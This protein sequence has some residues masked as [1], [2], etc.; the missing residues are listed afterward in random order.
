MCLG[1]SILHSNSSKF[2]NDNSIR[3]R[4][5][6]LLLAFKKKK[7]RNGDWE[8]LSYFP[9]DI[10]L[11]T[12]ELCIEILSL[13]H[14]FFFSHFVLLPPSYSVHTPKRTTL[15]LFCQEPKLNPVLA[16]K[17]GERQDCWVSIKLSCNTS[18]ILQCWL[19][20]TSN[21]SELFR[22]PVNLN[23]TSVIARDVSV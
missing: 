7:K 17:K 1:L 21:N 22:H 12:G 5:Q 3:E 11:S 16:F 20:Y 18:Y 10:K 9:T 19:L 14:D 2:I 4:E 15:L 8:P 13:I 6:F 23:A